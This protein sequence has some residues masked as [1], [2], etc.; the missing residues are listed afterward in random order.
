VHHRKKRAE[1]EA[2][3]QLQYAQSIAKIVDAAE[4]QIGA[5]A[6]K[7]KTA[8]KQKADQHVKA[9]EEQSRQQKVVNIKLKTPLQY[10]ILPFRL[11][12]LAVKTQCDP[13]TVLSLHFIVCMPGYQWFPGER[14]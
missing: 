6:R 13:S 8:D 3:Q 7:L 12:R 14:L 2:K 11:S 4:E 10:R 9:Q 1:A 5:H